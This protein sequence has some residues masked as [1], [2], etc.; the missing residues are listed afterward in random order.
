[1]TPSDVALFEKWRTNRDADAFAALLSRHAGMVYGACL[2]V[3]RDPGM[4]EEVS[5]ECFIELMKGPRV[6]ECL[7]GWL[8]T[9][10]T[11]RALDRAKSDGRRKAREQAYATQRGSMEEAT[12]DDTRE[13]VDEA[14]AAL[15][16]ELRV[17]IILRFLGGQP[18]QAIADEL[19]VSRST[20][21]L[22]IDKG[23]GIVRESL[24]K[25]GILTTVAAL[26]AMLES[27]PAAAAPAT[28]VSE[29]GRRALAAR[30]GTGQTSAF[31][32]AKIAAAPLAVAG[33]VLAGYWATAGG[34]SEATISLASTGRESGGESAAQV[35]TENPGLFG[36]PSSP[37]VE[38]LDEV[39][40]VV[41]ENS[42]EQQ[43]LET[44]E[45]KDRWILDLTPT[46]ETKQRLKVPVNIDFRGLHAQKVLYILQSVYDINLVL[47]SQTV[48]P[49]PREDGKTGYRKPRDFATDGKLPRINHRDKSLDEVLA[50]LSTSLGLTYKVRGNVVWVSSSAEISRELTVPPPSAPF[51]EAEILNVLGTPVQFD[52]EDIHVFD[53]LDWVRETYD[54]N[55]V[56]DT[57]V[58]MPE[59][60]QGE[61]PPL[62]T[63]S[64]ATDGMVEQLFLVRVSLAESLYA[65][66]RLLEL[67][68]RVD[69]DAVYISTPELIKQRF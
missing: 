68:Y 29:L 22:R 66:T 17:P 60:K 37:S 59:V 35:P 9:V 33:L 30:S 64:Y 40:E 45:A 10:A 36:T 62:D 14:I 67:T 32:A 7:G 51:G 25:R 13:F 3:L 63:S 21:R 55:I 42:A 65:L 58:I 39:G 56:A 24:A 8:H 27:I 41:V 50:I 61:E 20:V 52:F 69:R 2:R 31:T 34:R 26:S 5:Q 4:A 19:A 18:H 23:I 16:E 1:M 44:A 43:G 38:T 47:D 28:L 6:A 53:I 12:W 15:P 49:N 46:E 48:A 54:I 11:R 57:R